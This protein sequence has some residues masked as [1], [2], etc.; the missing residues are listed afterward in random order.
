MYGKPTNHALAQKSISLFFGD[1]HEDFGEATE[2]VGMEPIAF[3]FREL[4]RD[5]EA[6]PQTL[7]T[8]W[9]AKLDQPIDYPVIALFAV[10]RDRL[11]RSPFRA[12]RL[13]RCMK[14][15]GIFPPMR[16]AA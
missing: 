3:L 9:A 2:R 8:L 12:W 7:M 5:P 10:T 16:L 13:M 15:A 1:L 6:T 14:K 4:G 11:F